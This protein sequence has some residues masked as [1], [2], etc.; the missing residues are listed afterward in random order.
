MTE[1]DE[2]RDD[3]LHMLC[4]SLLVPVK[5]KEDRQLFSVAERWGI[6]CTLLTFNSWH[7]GQ[8]VNALHGKAR[9]DPTHK[10]ITKQNVINP[11]QSIVKSRLQQLSDGKAD[12]YDFSHCDYCISGWM[13][14][15]YLLLLLIGCGLMQMG[16]TAEKHTLKKTPDT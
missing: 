2:E 16:D 4:P 10:S 5:E 14:A 6:F 7:N 13:K 11:T 15:L 8:L 3:G 12:R 1:S 9:K